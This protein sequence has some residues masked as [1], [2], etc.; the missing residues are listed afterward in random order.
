MAYTGKTWSR[1]D[2][3]TSAAMNNIEGGIEEA[4]VAAEDLAVA[5]STLVN[6]LQILEHRI[7]EL[8][9]RL[10]EAFDET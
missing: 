8:S 1:G 6:A 4:S 2:M 7:N 9:A 10:D 5:V 3:I